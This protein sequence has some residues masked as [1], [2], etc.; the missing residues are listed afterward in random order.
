[1]LEITMQTTLYTFVL[2][3]SGCTKNTIER[4]QITRTNTKPHLF[5][6]QHNKDLQPPLNLKTSLHFAKDKLH[7]FFFYNPQNPLPPSNPKKKG[8]NFNPT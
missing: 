2:T 3:T 6:F 4:L 7:L 8:A 5:V 1:M